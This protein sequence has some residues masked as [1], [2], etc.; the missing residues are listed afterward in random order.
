MASPTCS[1]C[2][3]TLTKKIRAPVTCMYCNHEACQQCF[4]KFLLDSN[5]T[6]P[7]CMACRRPWN[8][9]FV[10]SQ[11]PKTFLKTEYANKRREILFGL[12]RAKLPGTMD[13]AARFKEATEI[14]A[15][16]KAYA[17]RNR[18]IGRAMDAIKNTYQVGYTRTYKKRPDYVALD[19]E[20]K[21]IAQN[22]MNDRMRMD[23][24]RWPHLTAAQP[25]APVPLALPPIF[26]CPLPECRGFAGGAS[27]DACG[28]CKTAVCQKCRQTM[29]G[30][31]HACNP[32][33]VETVKA[34]KKDTKPC[35]KCAA[36]IFKIDGCDQ[37]WCLA[38][39]TAFSWRTGEIE[40]GRVHNPEYFRWLRE[41]GQH[42]PRADAV[43]PDACVG[44]TL[45]GE[46]ILAMRFNRLGMQ[47]EAWRN[48]VM[49]ALR[50]VVHV[51]YVTLPDLRARLQR[52]GDLLAGTVIFPLPTQGEDP[53]VDLRVRYL[54][55]FGIKSDAEFQKRLL[56]RERELERVRAAMD[57][58]DMLLAAAT[59]IFQRAA[60]DEHCKTLEDLAEIAHELENLRVYF[61]DSVDRLQARFDCKLHNMIKKYPPFYTA[62]LR[63]LPGTGE[64]QMIEAPRQQEEEDMDRV[65]ARER[66][67]D[68][69]L[70]ALV[71]QFADHP[72]DIAM[73]FRDLIH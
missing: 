25:T 35:P 43:A 40:R 50:E 54:V 28:L 58:H 34:L 10:E 61:N 48:G 13:L 3:E 69:M 23:A 26:P 64:Q 21:Q 32:D 18:E 67:G 6:E 14:Q 49:H 11:V 37:M 59:P 39:K 52:P 53:Y 30:D 44:D 16:M 17:A 15:R 20:K 51:R 46:G 2:C 8:A 60:S 70:F 56:N 72:R 1:I 38:C 62:P 22:Y 65:R 57:L 68:E 63:T 42:I 9:E 66:Q 71:M 45:P 4:R 27:G 36:P 7:S 12:E 5:Q 24:I 31:E 47:T 41:S 29:E 55:G 19:E 73:A 33:D